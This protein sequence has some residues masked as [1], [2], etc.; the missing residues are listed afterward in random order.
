MK[1]NYVIEYR[2]AKS[3]FWRRTSKV[4]TTKKS[5]LKE[6]LAKAKELNEEYYDARI[7]ENGKL[8]HTLL[9]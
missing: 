4:H 9:V 8:I 3:D 6:A 5:T 1:K 2:F 7:Y